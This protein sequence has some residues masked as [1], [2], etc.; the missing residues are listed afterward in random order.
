MSDNDS[1][2]QYQ[3]EIAMTAAALP[4]DHTPAARRSLFVTPTETALGELIKRFTAALGDSGV[5]DYQAAADA[6]HAYAAEVEKTFRFDHEAKKLK[7]TCCENF[8][9]PNKRMVTWDE[10]ERYA[11]MSPE[12]RKQPY[13]AGIQA[14]G[15]DGAF[16]LCR[17]CP[18]HPEKEPDGYHHLDERL[19]ALQ[20]I[21][22]DR[23]GTFRRPNPVFMRAAYMASLDP[24]GFAS[25][26]RDHPTAYDLGEALYPGGMEI[27]GQMWKAMLQPV[28]VRS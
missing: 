1:H 27:L 5:P 8:R 15:M 20:Q 23:L 10:F 9:H 22:A 14:D 25:L 19:Q 13:K 7:S 21:E 6:V 28:L 11:A 26:M 16:R 24:E 12:A 4:D 3:I 2:L 18:D 17:N